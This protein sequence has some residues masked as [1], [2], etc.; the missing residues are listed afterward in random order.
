MKIL[1]INGPNLNLLGKRDS[2]QYGSLTLKDIE[3]LVKKEYKNDIIEFFQSNIEGEI[4]EQIQ[5]SINYFDG[6][7]INAGGYSHTSVSIRD[8]L[9]IIKIPKIEV[10]LSNLANREQFRQTLITAP[11]C[12]GYISGFREKG[13]LAAVYLLKMMTE[14]NYA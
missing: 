4:I 5:K 13:Y 14:N 7:I 2:T 9:D 3:N 6:L 1:I 10:H 11:V 12:N 8:A